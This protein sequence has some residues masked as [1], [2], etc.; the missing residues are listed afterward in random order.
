LIL[1]RYKVYSPAFMAKATQSRAPT[2]AT[3]VAIVGVIGGALWQGFSAENEGRLSFLLWTTVPTIALA[4]LALVRA[5]QR[6]EIARWLKP[7]WGDITRGFLIGLLLFVSSWVFV[8]ITVPPGSPH[9]AWMARIYLMMGDTSR[10]RDHMVLVAIG[11]VIASAAEEV[12]WRGLVVDLAEKLVGVRYAWV[13]GGILYAL[14]HVGTVMSLSDEKAGPN[15]LLLIAALGCGL[16]W[17]G[18]RRSFGRLPPAIVAHALFDWTVVM[19]F[20]LWGPSV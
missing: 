13:F 9:E 14:A 5:Y 12:V 8:K 17:S 7:E 10:L 6:E 11:I 18:V 19:M 16:V 20:R 15:P 4:I 2:I 1:G 3:L